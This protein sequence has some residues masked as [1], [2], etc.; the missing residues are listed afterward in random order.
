MGGRYALHYGK[1][2]PDAA[3]LLAAGFIHHVKR[4]GDAGQV[5]LYEAAFNIVNEGRGIR[6]R[7]EYGQ[8][9]RH[10]IGGQRAHDK[11]AVVAGGKQLRRAEARQYALNRG[12]KE[13]EGGSNCTDDKPTAEYGL[14]QAGANGSFHG[15]ALS[16]P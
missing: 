11:V 14:P 5:F 10:G 13:Y 16:F 6:Q 7:G 12:K 9:P 1:A 2:K 8:G 3:L 4:L 15:F